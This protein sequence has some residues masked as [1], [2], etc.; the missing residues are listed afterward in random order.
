MN[1]TKDYL[2]HQLILL[3]ARAFEAAEN[4]PTWGMEEYEQN[5]DILFPGKTDK[6]VM[7]RHR[8]WKKLRGLNY[9]N[10]CKR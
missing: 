2:D 5:P 9:Y 6:D 4:K 3:A 10:S 8:E 7:K 1:D